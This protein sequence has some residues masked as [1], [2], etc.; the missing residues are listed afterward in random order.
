MMAVSRRALLSLW[1]E[2]DAAV[3]RASWFRRDDA[4]DATL[5]AFLPL[6]AALV[7]GAPPPA[8]PE[9]SA[10]EAALAEVIACDQVP[11]NCHRGAARAYEAD[12]AALALARAAVAGGALGRLPHAWQRLFLLMPFMHCEDAAAHAEAA[13]LWPPALAE[14]ARKHEAVV[15]RFGRFP[16]RNELLGRASTQEELEHL[17]SPERQAWERA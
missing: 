9:L 7:A 6:T 5:R 8:E 11:R 15:A 14:F 10:D 17:A 1:F 3:E 4:F 16:H 2:G 12:A 13:P